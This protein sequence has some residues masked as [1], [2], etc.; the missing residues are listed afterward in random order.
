MA[1]VMVENNDG[2][3]SEYRD[4]DVVLAEVL[5]DEVGKCDHC[6]VTEI[7]ELLV[8]RGGGRYCEYC[9]GDLHRR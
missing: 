8:R 6:G 2:T 3:V 7:A 1:K 5:G 9:D 4:L